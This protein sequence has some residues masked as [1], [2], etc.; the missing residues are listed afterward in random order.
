MELRLA[1]SVSAPRVARCAIHDALTERSAEVREVVALLVDELVTNAIVH[2]RGEIGLRV[3]DFPGWIRV[4]VSDT[5]RFGPTV[6]SPSPGDEH[7]R[8]MM[9][10]A[11]LASSWGIV[12]TPSGKGVWFRLDLAE[13]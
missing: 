11:S 13:Q 4:E 12:R 1:D 3:E 6:R 2:A 10:V 7:G 8:G 5:A 9:I